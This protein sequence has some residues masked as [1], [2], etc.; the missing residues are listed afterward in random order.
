METFLSIILVVLVFPTL[1][2][3]S[4]PMIAWIVE[5]YMMWKEDY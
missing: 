1:V 5:L 4:L 3:L 2:I